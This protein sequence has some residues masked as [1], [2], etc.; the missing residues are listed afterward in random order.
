MADK[1]EPMMEKARELGRLLGQTNEYQTLKRARERVSDDRE[2]TELLNRL[3]EL[4]RELTAALQRGE[5]PAQE[6][7]D[8][9]EEMVSKL[10]ASSIYQSLIAAQSN[11]DKVVGRVNEAMAEGM[12]SGAQSRIILSS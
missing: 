8:E 4:E 7:R 9:Y 1:N 10:Q 2:I 6:R 11:F 5:T 3:G 12:E